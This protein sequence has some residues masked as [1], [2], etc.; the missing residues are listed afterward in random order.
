[1][2][3]CF[4][5]PVVG[6]NLEVPGVEQVDGTGSLLQVQQPQE[7]GGVVAR[8]RGEQD[9]IHPPHASRKPKLE[10]EAG[11]VAALLTI[12]QQGEGLVDAEDSVNGNADL[13]GDDLPA[14]AAK[15][16]PVAK[17]STWGQIKSLVK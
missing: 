1:M 11:L 8:S 9:P 6:F 13:A 16:V 12:D 2:I 5:N 3:A 4:D 7:G 17:L 10:L 15:P 14:E